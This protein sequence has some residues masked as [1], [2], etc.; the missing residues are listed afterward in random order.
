MTVKELIIQMSKIDDKEQAV[1]VCLP[2]YP[3][4]EVL[5][6]KEDRDSDGSVVIL[7]PDTS[8]FE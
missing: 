5:E 2:G 6:V 3:Y 1:Y 4:F 8:E 7:M